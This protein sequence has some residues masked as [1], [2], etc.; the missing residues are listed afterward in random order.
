MPG[1]TGLAQISGR[2]HLSWDQKLLYDNLYVDLYAIHGS[3]LDIFIMV[4]TCWFVIK[5]RNTIERKT[6]IRPAEGCVTS[7]AHKFGDP[8][9]SNVSNGNPPL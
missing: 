7:L 5:T 3:M 1:I 8:S 4:G 6:S 9:G 2:N